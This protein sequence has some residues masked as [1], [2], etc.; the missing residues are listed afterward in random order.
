MKKLHYLLSGLTVV[1]VALSLNRLT[2]LTNGH[3]QPYDFLRWVDFNA[4]I[5][6]PLATVL[7]Y[8]LVMRDVRGHGRYYHGRWL[9]WLELVFM[10]GVV[11]YAVSSGDH[12]PTN[13]F[14]GHFCADRMVQ[15]R[16]CDAIAYHDDGFSH[17]LYYAGVILLTLGLLGIERLR[18]RVAAMRGSDLAIVLV[19]AGLIA[20]G[21]FANLAFEPAQIDLVAFSMLA[22]VSLGCLLTARAWIGRLPVTVYLAA[23]YGLGL[24][25][26]GVYKLIA[27]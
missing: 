3:L 11:L 18:P 12:E 7:L 19:N 8:Y 25:A 9:V 16:L 24:V 13:Y 5:I 22:V 4:M 2:S 23:A 15:P 26:T 6:I 27:R 21:I 1:I 14:H 20:A 10:A 17:Y